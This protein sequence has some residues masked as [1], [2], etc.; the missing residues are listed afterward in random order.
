[1]KESLMF[2]IFDPFEVVG[3]EGCDEEVDLN[4]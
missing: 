1:M 4:D 2:G 3:A